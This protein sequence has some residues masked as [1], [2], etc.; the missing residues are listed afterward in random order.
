MRPMRIALCQAHSEVATEGHDPRDANLAHAVE[1]IGRAAEEGANLAVFGE[2]FLNGYRSD[3][4]LRDV[5]SRLDPPDEH[6]ARLVEV[7]RETGVW[8]VMGLSRMGSIYPGNL[9][10]TNVLIGPEGVVGSYD[11]VHVANFVLP[12]GTVATEMV[13]WDVGHAYQVFDTPWCR[14]GLQICRDVRYPEASRVLTLLGAELI[15]NSTAAP[16]VK[17]PE[18]WRVEHFSTTRAIENQV[19]FAMSGVLGEQR[20]MTMLGNSRLVSPT[21]EVVVKVPDFEEAVVV[22]EIDI[23]AVARE[24]A[25][26]HVLD[27]RVPSAYAPITESHQDLARRSAATDAE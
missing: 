16:V 7:S 23:D 10:N 3:A 11:K 2:V 24:R 25:L 8:V 1:L 20:D 5:S 26:T 4:F 27:R 9:F 6:V 15:V 17:R 13:Y 12:D 22:C 14:V 18:E 21:G 19:W